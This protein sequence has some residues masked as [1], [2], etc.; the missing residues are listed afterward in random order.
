M[1]SGSSQ[2]PWGH[3][4]GDPRANRKLHSLTH[5]WPDLEVGE[6]DFLNEAPLFLQPPWLQVALQDLGGLEGSVALAEFHTELSAPPNE[7][8]GQ[9]TV[10]ILDYCT[11]CIQVPGGRTLH[12]VAF[13]NP[14]IL[15][16]LKLKS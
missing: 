14:C 11:L 6:P 2:A 3:S 4:T 7:V 1:T 8:T 9:A 12:K 15:M 16:T 10:A 5:T 13:V